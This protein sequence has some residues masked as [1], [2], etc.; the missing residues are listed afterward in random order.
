MTLEIQKAENSQLKSKLKELL[1][2][3]LSDLGAMNETARE[4]NF[5]R[6]NE[7]VLLCFGVNDTYPISRRNR[8]F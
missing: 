1:P 3:V 4:S 2:S 8:F 7:N 6:K 5:K